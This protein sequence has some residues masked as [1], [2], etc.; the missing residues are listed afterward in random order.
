MDGVRIRTE[1]NTQTRCEGVD[2]DLSIAVDNFTN[3]LV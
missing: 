3:L 1:S 2:I